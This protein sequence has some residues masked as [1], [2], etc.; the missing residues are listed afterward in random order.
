MTISAFSSGIDVLSLVFLKRFDMLSQCLTVYNQKFR[1]LLVR[2]GTAS[3]GPSNTK[4]SLK[5]FNIS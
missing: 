3:H 1:F 4:F 5:Y 2:S